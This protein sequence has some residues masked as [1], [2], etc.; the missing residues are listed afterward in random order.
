MTAVENKI[1]VV[2]GLVKKTDYNAKKI[3][4]TE[5]KLADHNHAKYITT[6]EFNKFT[7][8]NFDARLALANL[9]TYTDFDTKLI[10]LNK[11]YKKTLLFAENELKML[12]TFDSTYFRGKS[13]FEEDSTRNYLVFQPMYSILKELVMENIF[14][15]RNLKD[16]LMKILQSYVLFF[17]CT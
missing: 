12:Q 5:K 7:A 1:P 14:I 3:T 8:E 16:C 17:Y 13:H 15:F 2:T 6:P 10:S 11:N 4:E 9:I